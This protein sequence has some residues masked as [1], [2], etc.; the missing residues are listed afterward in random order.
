MRVFKLN[1]DAKL[2]VKSDED[3]CYDFFACFSGED[4][5]VYHGEVTTISLGVAVDLS[6]YHGSLRPRS[7]LARRG[8]D[9]LGGQ[10]DRSYRGELLVMLTSHDNIGPPIRIKSG[11][12]IVQMKLEEDITVAVEQVFSLD[13]LSV[14]DR[15]S[16]GFGSTG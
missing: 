16:N 2:P 3:M 12:K 13:D 10:I 11:D 1:D 5:Y 14:S 7:G 9:V 4:K 15:G 8:L 6:P